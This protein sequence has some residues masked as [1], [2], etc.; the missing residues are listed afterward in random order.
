MVFKTLTREKKIKNIHTLT[1]TNCPYCH[2][3]DPIYTFTDNW[4]ST[5][6]TKHIVL[7]HSCI[8]EE[9]DIF[10]ICPDYGNKV[11]VLVE[12]N[13]CPMCGRDLK[14]RNANE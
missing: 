10:E 12:F 1:A 13:F 8:N 11:G 7:S 6:A 9:D 5:L 14:G 2:K 4:N 3:S